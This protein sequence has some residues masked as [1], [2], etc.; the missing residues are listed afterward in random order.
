MKDVCGRCRGCGQIADCDSGE[1][2]TDWKGLP[3]GSNLL[4]RAGIVKPIPC[5]TCGGS[6]KTADARDTEKAPLQKLAKVEEQ[7]AAAQAELAKFRKLF[8]EAPDPGEDLSQDLKHDTIDVLVAWVKRSKAECEA[9][10]S[11]F[12]TGFRCVSEDGTI[13]EFDPEGIEEMHDKLAAA[14]A[15]EAKLREAASSVLYEIE[16]GEASEGDTRALHWCAE[17]LAAALS[18]VP[19]PSLAPCCGQ[20]DEAHDLT[21]PTCPRRTDGVKP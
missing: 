3:P 4:V 7:L 16:Y 17:T 9:K 15:R 8:V 21:S 12:D 14:Q 1:P 18:D 11:I 5:P 10:G 13:W 20:P 19:P 2:W 6:G